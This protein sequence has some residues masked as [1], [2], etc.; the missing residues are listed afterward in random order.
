VT[1]AKL[2][3]PQIKIS[4]LYHQKEKVQHAFSCAAEDLFQ[5]RAIAVS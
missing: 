4:G 5:E 2:E 1:Q 3:Y